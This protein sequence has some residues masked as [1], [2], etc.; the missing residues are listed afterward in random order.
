MKKV[1][2]G[3]VVTLLSSSKKKPDGYLVKCAKAVTKD[4]AVL[5]TERPVLNTPNE[6]QKLRARIIKANDG[7]PMSVHFTLSE[8][9]GKVVALLT[10]HKPH[11]KY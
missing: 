5:V 3:S 10:L 4:N 8:I 6:R 1:K 2:P 11:R 7:K 9:E